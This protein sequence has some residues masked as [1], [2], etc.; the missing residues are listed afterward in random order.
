[1]ICLEFLHGGY[2]TIEK[3]EKSPQGI[4]KSDVFVHFKEERRETPAGWFVFLVGSPKQPKQP[5][6]PVTARWI[7]NV[8]RK[9]LD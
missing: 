7:Q 9:L 4:H 5:G 8:C 1:M 3:S 6:F 2:L